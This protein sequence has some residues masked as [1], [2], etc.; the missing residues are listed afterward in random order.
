SLPDRRNDAGA[1]FRRHVASPNS[2]R[3]FR[4]SQKGP[5]SEPLNFQLHAIV[6]ATLVEFT[7][8]SCLRHFGHSF[9]LRSPSFNFLHALPSTI[10]EP[11]GWP[12]GEILHALRE[13]VVA[14]VDSD[15]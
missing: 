9:A 7:R 10:N 5:A 14:A 3:S 13:P 1:P 6:N 8:F 15:T 2:P 12:T 11:A 4:R